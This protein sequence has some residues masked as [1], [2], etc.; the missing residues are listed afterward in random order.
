MVRGTGEGLKGGAKIGDLEAHPSAFN[1]TATLTPG[2]KE[3]FLAKKPYFL[4][5]KAKFLIDHMKEPEQMI[6]TR[7]RSLVLYSIHYSSSNRVLST[8]QAKGN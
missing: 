1:T 3:H 6:Y 2:Q 4:S 8:R 5:N 7:I